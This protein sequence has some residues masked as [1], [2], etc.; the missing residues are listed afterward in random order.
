MVIMRAQ[1]SHPT[2]AFHDG[3]CPSPTGSGAIDE[4]DGPGTPYRDVIRVEIDSRR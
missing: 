2:S 4:S 1:P 3:V